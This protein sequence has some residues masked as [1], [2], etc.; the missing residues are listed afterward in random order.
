MASVKI[1][2]TIMARIYSA[3]GVSHGIAQN[4]EDNTERLS[5]MSHIPN[6]LINIVQKVLR[7]IM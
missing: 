5:K 6:I 7:D 1:I 4:A 3:K 2:I